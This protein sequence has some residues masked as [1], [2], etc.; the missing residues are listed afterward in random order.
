MESIV[1]A[2]TEPKRHVKQ[3][4]GF[5]QHALTF[6]VVIGFLTTLNLMI[7]PGRWW[8]QWIVFGWGIG[9]GRANT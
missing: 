1:P 6:I 3:L 8:F 2:Y 9:Q 4:R 5:Y 7:S